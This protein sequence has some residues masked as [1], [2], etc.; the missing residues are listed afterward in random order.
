MELQH[1]THDAG[2]ATHEAATLGGKTVPGGRSILMRATGG[3]VFGALRR[4]VR[5][6]SRGGWSAWRIAAVAILTYVVAVNLSYFFVLKPIWSRLNVLV[7]KKGVI[8]DFLIVRESA[9]AVSGFKDGLMHGD[10]RMTVVAEFEELAREAG[11]R[12]VGEP[13][14]LPPREV[15]KKLVEYPVEI[16]L[17]GTYH[18]VGHFMS[19]LEASPRCPLVTEV[20]VT[21]DEGGSRQCDVRLRIGIAS[22]VD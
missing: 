16:D 8:Q 13:G 15:S 6:G 2:G 7:E 11:L 19:L 14:L 4:L 5:P 10:Q 3:S 21:A 12:M 22:W 18:E 20:E 1:A 17:R 9:S